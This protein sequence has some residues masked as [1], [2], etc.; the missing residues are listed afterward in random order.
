MNHPVYHI[1]G[2][3]VIQPYQIEVEFE[4]GEKKCINLEPVLYG[5]MYGQLRDLNLF[6]KVS[7]DPEVKTIQWP[8]GADF[9]PEILKHWEKY[10]QE[11]SIRAKQWV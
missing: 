5:Q 2:V 8:N 9:D 3:T 6:Y 4:D 11:L 7:V 10:S 1:K